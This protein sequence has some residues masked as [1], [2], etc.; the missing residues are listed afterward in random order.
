MGVGAV[1]VNKTKKISPTKSR[2]IL[3]EAM[4]WVLALVMGVGAVPYPNPIGC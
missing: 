2:P 1:K 3:C 4:N